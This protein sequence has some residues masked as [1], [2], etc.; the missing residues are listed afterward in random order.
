MLTGPHPK[1]AHQ[2]WKFTL[3]I[4]N[5]FAKSRKITNFGH[6][7]YGPTR[8]FFEKSPIKNVNTGNGVWKFSLSTCKK[9]LS[10]QFPISF[11]AN[12]CNPPLFKQILNLN[13]MNTKCKKN[14]FKLEC[15]YFRI[16]ADQRFQWYP[17]VITKKILTSNLMWSILKSWRTSWG[18]PVDIMLFQE[19]F[20]DVL[21]RNL[22]K[23]FLKH[24]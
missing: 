19:R 1:G 6:F 15:L 16:F 17:E 7:A 12:Y 18:S 22:R 13:P 23:P 8:P 5:F 21:Q 20:R 10:T 14:Y 4:M 9:H 2:S 3:D 11:D 24:S